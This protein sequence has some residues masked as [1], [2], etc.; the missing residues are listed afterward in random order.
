MNRLP[1]V[2]SI[3]YTRP[4]ISPDL[5]TSSWKDKAIFLSK[6]Y[7]T[8]YSPVFLSLLEQVFNAQS[9]QTLVSSYALCCQY[10]SADLWL[11]LFSSF[12]ILSPVTRKTMATLRLSSSGWNASCTGRCRFSNPASGLATQ[13]VK[14]FGILLGRSPSYVVV[15]LTENDTWSTFHHCIYA[16]TWRKS[17]PLRLIIW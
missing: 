14:Y 7:K 11:Q 12:E 8:R 5:R 2:S 15:W 9:T 10:T 17:T 13:T 4:G 6:Y 3:I 1:K 16:F